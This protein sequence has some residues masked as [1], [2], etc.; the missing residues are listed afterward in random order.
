MSKYCAIDFEYHSTNE[1]KF[2]LVCCSALYRDRTYEFW[3]NDKSQWDECKNFFKRVRDEQGIL[4]CF[5]AVAEGSSLYSLNLDIRKFN[6]IDIQAEYKMLLNKNYKFMYGA[7][8]VNGAYKVTSPPKN[9]WQMTEED[10]KDAQHDS[11]EHNLLAVTH[12]LLGVD[13]LK[14]KEIKD[15]MRDIILTKD[16]YLI[17]TNKEAIQKYCT[18]D[19]YNLIPLWLKIKQEYIDYFN[20]GGRTEFIPT[21]EEILFRGETVARSGLIQQYGYPVDI[22]KLKTLISNIPK[23]MQDLMFDINSQFQWELFRKNIKNEIGYSQNQK[24]WKEY[25]SKSEYA[26]VWTKTAGGGVS[27]ELKAFQK[28]FSY[29]HDYP[30]G[31]FF[32]Q[33][34]RYLKTKQALMS[35]LP[36]E[37]KES[38]LDYVGSDNRIRP[39][40]NSYGSQTSRFQPKANSF[41]FLK[42]SWV[43]GLVHPPKG[44]AIV[45]IDYKS[46]E[47]L[48]GALLSEDQGMIEAYK[49]GDVYLDFAKRAGAVPQDGT[50]DKYKKERDLFKSTY[51]GISYLMG[52]VSLSKKLSMDTGNK[53]SEEDAKDLIDKFYKAYPKYDAYLKEVQRLYKVKKFH[54]LQDGWILFGDNDNF[55]S[56]SN[57]PIQ[58]TGSCIIRK[59]I[60]YTQDSGLNIIFPFHDAIYIECDLEDVISSVDLLANCMIKAFVDCFDDKE[61]SKLIG[62]DCEAWGTGLTKMYGDNITT[63]QK[64]P[65]HLEE[66]HIDPRGL[67]EYKLYS[68]YFTPNQAN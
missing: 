20:V 26:N 41:L 61:N 47:A 37:H 48:I 6:W 56:V 45:G 62:L 65:V 27:L 40:L 16:F 18:S 23:I 1:N 2:H 7:Q 52:P 19:I 64:Y 55:R 49:S 21:R 39:Y 29:T 59:A 35:M 31:N 46:E 4:I 51:L 50:K 42:P 32:A 12:K 63:R 3:L 24:L 9:K 10:E 60:K 67:N 36:R 15:K 11:P 53:Y 68:K 30:R 17:E 57:M 54:K 13:V 28:H 8:F 38:L 14:N 22:E 33:I 25:I 5:N 66:I 34:L 44:R 43:R 58:G